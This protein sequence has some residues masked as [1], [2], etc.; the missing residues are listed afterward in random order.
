M[1]KGRD[2]MDRGPLLD[3]RFNEGS[4]IPRCA[5]RQNDAVIEPTTP[6]LLMLR[7]LGA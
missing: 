2:L 6:A 5:I 3:F 7:P 4:Q 1:K